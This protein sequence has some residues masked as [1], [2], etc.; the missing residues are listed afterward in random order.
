MKLFSLNRKNGNKFEGAYLNFEVHKSVARN[1]AFFSHF[2]SDLVLPC[3][4]DS[5]SSSSVSDGALSSGSVARVGRHREGTLSS[6]APCGGL[7]CNIARHGKQG[8]DILQSSH[9]V[10]RCFRISQGFHNVCLQKTCSQNTKFGVTRSFKKLSIPCSS[11]I[12]LKNRAKRRNQKVLLLLVSHRNSWCCSGDN[13]FFSGSH[14]SDY[15]E[16][17]W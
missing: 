17:A 12:L 2:D 15:S 3:L 8:L 10:F 5:R 4:R 13:S 14:I 9:I 1:P 6:H 11:L 7:R 16:P